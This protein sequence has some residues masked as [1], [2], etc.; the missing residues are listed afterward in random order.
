MPGWLMT[1]KILDAADF[2]QNDIEKN[3]ELVLNVINNNTSFELLVIASALYFL[4]KILIK[5]W[6]VN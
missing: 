1:S 3:R 6:A 2:K 4:R 5:Y